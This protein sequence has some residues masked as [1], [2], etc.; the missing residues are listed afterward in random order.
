MP[1]LTVENGG[2]LCIVNL[3]ATEKDNAAHVRVFDYCDHFILEVAQQLAMSIPLYV[4]STDFVVTKSTV[5]CEPPFFTLDF[6]KKG[7]K[8]AIKRKNEEKDDKSRKK[9]RKEE[10]DTDTTT[11][12]TANTTTEAKTGHKKEEDN[13]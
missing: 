8:K 4:P 11:T 10:T 5:V 9:Q 2:K 6:P 13:Q 7:D 1:L 3:Q 12:A